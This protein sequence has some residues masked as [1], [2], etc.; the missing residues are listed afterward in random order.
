MLRRSLLAL[1]VVACSVAASR[2]EVMR[3]QDVVLD[4][5]Q[6][7]IDVTAEILH[8]ERAISCE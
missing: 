3:N 7:C 2:A 5:T 8:M 6:P 1:L 4:F